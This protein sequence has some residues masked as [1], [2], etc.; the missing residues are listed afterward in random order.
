MNTQTNEYGCTQPFCDNTFTNR[1]C[2]YPNCE[3]GHKFTT[4]TISDFTHHNVAMTPT[5]T[6]EV[7]Y[8]K[9]ETVN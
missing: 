1:S 9:Y 2:T 5:T 3:D 7:V 6:Y 8:M 4:T